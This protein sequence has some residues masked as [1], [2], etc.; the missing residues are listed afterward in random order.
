M[1]NTERIRCRKCGRLFLRRD[2]AERH[3]PT[4]RG[5]FEALFILLK[6]NSK[7]EISETLEYFRIKDYN[8]KDY[9]EVYANV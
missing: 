6:G 4:H 8:R 9:L 2:V 3:V 7:E 5:F 1:I